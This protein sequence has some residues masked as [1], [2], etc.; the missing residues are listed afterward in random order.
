MTHLDAYLTAFSLSCKIAAAQVTK[1]KRAKWHIKPWMKVWELP[2]GT[3]Q[4][5]K[6]RPKVGKHVG[7]TVSAHKVAL[8]PTDEEIKDWYLSP[9][10][11]PTKSAERKGKFYVF[12]TEGLEP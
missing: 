1:P 8:Y 7:F 2:D 9:I 5:R 6:R 10:M 3:L 12:S 11:L 4:A